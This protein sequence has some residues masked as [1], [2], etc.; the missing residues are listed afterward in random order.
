METTPTTDGRK[1]DFQDISLGLE[2]HDFFEMSKPS[3]GVRGAF[4]ALFACGVLLCSQHA[5]KPA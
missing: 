1:L 4:D 3:G 2:S 5:P